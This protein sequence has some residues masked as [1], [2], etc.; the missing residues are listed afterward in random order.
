MFVHEYLIY[1]LPFSGPSG[2]A[3]FVAL[4]LRSPGAISAGLFAS[5]MLKE[6]LFRVALST[7]HRFLFF[8]GENV[9]VPDPIALFAGIFQECSVVVRGMARGLS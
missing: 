4:V 2:G 1:F 5:L 6:V 3:A 7:V 8:D 9:C